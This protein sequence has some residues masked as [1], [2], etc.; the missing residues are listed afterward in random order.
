MALLS[1]QQQKLLNGWMRSASKDREELG[2]TK[3]DMTAAIAAT[4][5]WIEANQAAFNLALP[6]ASR[7]SLTAVQKTTLFCAVAAYRVNESFIVRL[8]GEVD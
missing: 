5:A 4:D 1:Q 6:V 2:L 7:T 3:N 8:F